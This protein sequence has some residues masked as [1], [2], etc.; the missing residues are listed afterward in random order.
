[1]C[2]GVVGVHHLGSNCFYVKRSYAKSETVR[3][4]INPFYDSASSAL[5]VLYCTDA[6]VSRTTLPVGV[7]AV[8]L[9][10][11]KD[12][13]REELSCSIGRCWQS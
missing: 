3:A 4:P 6:A 5:L 7:D 12:D 13:K 2:F 10:S 11:I 8:G 9:I 1:M